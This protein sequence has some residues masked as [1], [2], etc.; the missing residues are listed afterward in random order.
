MLVDF[1]TLE[2]SRIWIYQCNRKFSDTEFSEIEIGR[3]F[4]KNCTA[5]TGLIVIST[6]TIVL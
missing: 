1:N 3:P 5:C 2:E 6:Y 4:L